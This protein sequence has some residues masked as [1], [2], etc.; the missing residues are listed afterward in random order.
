MTVKDFITVCN[1]NELMACIA[2][3]K[4]F[5]GSEATSARYLPVLQELEGITPITDREQFALGMQTEDGVIVLCFD[6]SEVRALFDTNSVLAQ[7]REDELLQS[8]TLTEMAA[9]A[10]VPK[11]YCFYLI[12]WE[13]VL[14][15]QISADNIREIGAEQMA[16]RVLTDM[17]DTGFT[18][19]AA[20]ENRKK[21][22]GL[23]NSVEGSR[24]EDIL[25]NAVVHISNNVPT[26]EEMLAQKRT[27][28]LNNYRVYH[29]LKK[30]SDLW[31]E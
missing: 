23:M 9:M 8:N 11:G 4:G 14:A 16:A 6:V 31:R 25:E 1:K 12:A 27:Q 13:E 3:I 20:E 10:Y 22:I 17:T 30:Y 24:L 15:M 5:S 29:L 7:V 2:E 18:L 19:A 26:E 28:A 21:V